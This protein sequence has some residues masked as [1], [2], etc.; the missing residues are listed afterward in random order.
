MAAVFGFA[1]ADEHAL[2]LEGEAVAPDM[3]GVDAAFLQLEGIGLREEALEHAQLSVLPKRRGR[4]ISVTWSSE[5]HHW[6]MKSVLSTRKLS[7]SRKPVNP[8]APM[9]IVLPASAPPSSN[10]L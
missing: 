9:E 7:R 8:C 2:A 3:L 5:V 6:R 4:Q 10:N 1:L